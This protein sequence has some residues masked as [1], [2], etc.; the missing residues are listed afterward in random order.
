MSL[1]VIPGDEW[2][3]M[4]VIVKKKNIADITI[5]LC[6][7]YFGDPK[8][9]PKAANRAL[10]KVWRPTTMYQ[11]MVTETKALAN[12]QAAP[13]GAEREDI[14]PIIP[15]KWE[16]R[17]GMKCTRAWRKLLL[18]KSR[19]RKMCSGSKGKEEIQLKNPSSQGDEVKH[20]HCGMRLERPSCTLETPMKK[21]S[22]W[23][24][25]VLFCEG[26]LA[27]DSLLAWE[28][29]SELLQLDSPPNGKIC[30]LYCTSLCS[31]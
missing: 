11:I 1:H 6:L 2:Q 31:N 13:S 17:Q 19:V 7:A 26:W 24:E 4:V 25:W 5:K 30:R 12:S 20:L 27:A 21:I 8:A 9:N 23:K 16:T 18:P 29:V 10:V 15:D 14:I 3:C 22:M 28:L